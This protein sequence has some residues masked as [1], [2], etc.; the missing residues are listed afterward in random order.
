MKKYTLLIITG[1]LPVVAA[2]LAG[3]ILIPVSYE[4]L[5]ALLNQPLASHPPLGTVISYGDNAGTEPL[6]DEAI[7]VQA[8][9]AYL[10]KQLNLILVETPFGSEVRDYEPAPAQICLRLPAR[11][12][13]VSPAPSPVELILSW[14]WPLKK[15][16]NPV[17]DSYAISLWHPST[18]TADYVLM[19]NQE[20][21]LE[22]PAD[23]SVACHDRTGEVPVEG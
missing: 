23:P 5:P 19:A 20:E 6:L 21:F 22:A 1:I 11:P 17:Y 12:A 7:R 16:L 9:E 3:L 4:T 14:E 15:S 8:P 18:T 10:Q 2:I 13:L